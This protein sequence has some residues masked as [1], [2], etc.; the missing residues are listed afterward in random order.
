MRQWRFHVKFVDSVMFLLIEYLTKYVRLPSATD[1]PLCK[2]GPRRF[3]V[4]WSGFR[5]LWSLGLQTLPGI[6]VWVFTFGPLSADSLNID[7]F[8]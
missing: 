4:T 8:L 1:G 3:H 2:T 6:E 7:L 5:I